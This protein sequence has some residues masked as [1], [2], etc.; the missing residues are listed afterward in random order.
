MVARAFYLFYVILMISC[1]PRNLTY[2][3]DID[4][5]TTNVE[6]ITNQVDPWIQPNDL[7]SITVTSLNTETNI[8]FNSGVLQTAGGVN[9]P[10]ASTSGK[11][12]IGYLVDK[13]GFVTFPVVGKVQLGGMTKEQATEK[14]TTI[15]GEYVRDPI[16]DIGFQNFK[17][18]VI[19]EVNNPSTFTVPTERINVLEALGLAGDMT[20][21][22]KRDN[23]LILREQ[24]GQRITTRLNLNNKEVLN[25]PYFYLQQNDIIY[26]EPDR[27]KA[28]QVSLNRAN[29]QYG[30]SVGL[31]LVSL[32]AILI[33]QVF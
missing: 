22:G 26:V 3:S 31:A 23:V 18:T 25:S 20:A 19:G 12:S 5:K 9:N 16:V 4:E 24:G 2:L 30:L 15:L 21:F 13:H 10:T 1:S 7:L 32:A 27:A 11:G 28:V 33:T 6:E 14:M 29:F 17:V 8:L